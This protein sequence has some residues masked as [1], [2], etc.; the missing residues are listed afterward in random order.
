M[1]KRRIR[2]LA[3]AMLGLLVALAACSGDSDKTEQDIVMFFDNKK[4]D[5]RPPEEVFEFFGESRIAEYIPQEGEFLWDCTTNEECD[6]G[7]CVVTKQGG[8]CTTQCVE[9]CP[10]GW[11]CVEAD[12]KPDLIYIC[13]PRYTTLCDPCATNDD[14]K[15]P[16]VDTAFLDLCLEYPAGEGSFCGADCSQDAAGCPTG[17]ACTTVT[18]PGGDF[19]QC[20]PESNVC[21]CSFLAIQEAKSTTCEN[22]SEFGNC[23]GNRACS[24]QGLAP[25]DALIPIEEMCDDIDNDCDGVIDEGCDDDGDGFCDSA[26]QTSGKP[27]ICGNGGGD[28]NDADVDVYPGATE[29]C[30]KKDNDCNGTIDDGLCEDG[31][32]CTDDLCDPEEGCSHP[33]NAAVCDDGSTCTVN[34]HC[35]EGACS[36][37]PKVCDDGNSCTTDL[38]DPVSV[39][40]CYFVN[41]SDGCDD[42]GNVCTIDVCENG[43][44]QHKLATDLPCDDGNPCTDGDMCKSG[45]CVKGGP[46]DCDDDDLCTSDVC[47][48]VQGCIN[49]VQIGTPC[50]F[51]VLGICSVSGTC[52]SNGCVPQPNCQCPNCALCVCCGF[53]QLCVDNI[54]PG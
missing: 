24:A 27:A 38:C 3:V 11:K 4:V 43:A 9:D 10:S 35:F 36:G 42:D 50:S 54:F 32:P 23:A 16:G 13:V 19:Q 26:Q 51:D 44:C 49:Q 47:D 15:Q 14:C 48:Q 40:G 12:T 34:D 21:E 1:T 52:G 28:C 25:C 53:F 39:Q 6:S 45:Q 18:T 17:Y 22:V 31:N 33:L 5:V 20:M 30:D 8:K 29:K 37:S 2:L 7:F 41:N 46:K